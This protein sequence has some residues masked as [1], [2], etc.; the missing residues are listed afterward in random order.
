MLYGM[1]AIIVAL[2][3]GYFLVGRALHRDK[4]D[5]NPGNGA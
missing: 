2:S 3:L 4:A 5:T 1:A